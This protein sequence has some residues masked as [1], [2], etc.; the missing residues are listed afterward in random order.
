MVGVS[1]GGVYICIT[2][3]T[4]IGV[5]PSVSLRVFHGIYSTC[6]LNGNGGTGHL[7]Q[8]FTHNTTHSK[9]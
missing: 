7:A 8:T 9:Y 5:N 6:Q 1:A 2:S 4:S 3:R